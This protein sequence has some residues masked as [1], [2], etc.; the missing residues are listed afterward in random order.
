MNTVLVLGGYGA[1]GGRIAERL[2]ALRPE[3][4]AGMTRE[5][6]TAALKPWGVGTKQTW[7]TDPE[8]GEGANRRGFIRED[9]LKAI[10]QR[11]R[12]QGGKA[13]G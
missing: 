13:A 5:Q 10:T 1:F 4:Y 6:L 7:G 8:T 9:I 3:L 11:D 2:A 12:N